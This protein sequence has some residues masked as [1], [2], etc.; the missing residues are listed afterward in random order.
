QALAQWGGAQQCE[1][2][3]STSPSDA[4]RVRSAHYWPT[5]AGDRAVVLT[6]ASNKLFQGS[7]QVALVKT[8]GRWKIS[9]IGYCSGSGPATHVHIDTTGSPATFVRDVLLASY[10]GD[11]ADACAQLSLQALAQWGGAQQCESAVS[12]SPSDAARVRSAH[13]WPTVA[14]D[15]AVVL[16]SASNELFQGSSQVDLV[17]TGGRWKISCIGYCSGP[18]P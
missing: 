6:S 18:N 16:T 12:M 2:A 14:G 3:V 17:K 7:S 15:R 10:S 11:A 4:A 8:G 1:S 9:C 5:V 13:Y